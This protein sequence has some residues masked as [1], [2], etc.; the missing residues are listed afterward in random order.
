MGWRSTVLLVVSR[1]VTK[2]MIEKKHQATYK[3]T[4]L[5]SYVNQTCDG[6][7]DRIAEPRLKPET[8]LNFKVMNGYAVLSQF[9]SITGAKWLGGN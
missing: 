4:G 2:G 6:T 9:L 5:C 8:I 3:D 1:K 7:S